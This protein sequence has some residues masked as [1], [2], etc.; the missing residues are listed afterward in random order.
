MPLTPGPGSRYWRRPVSGAAP[1]PLWVLSSTDLMGCGQLR[2][3]G[4]EGPR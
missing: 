3:T 4:Q 1:G 2:A